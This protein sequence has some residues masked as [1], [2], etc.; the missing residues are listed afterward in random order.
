MPAAEQWESY[1]DAA[2]ILESLGCCHV[3]GD[4]VE[5]GCGY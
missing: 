1:F 2:G 5:F 3:R 4:A